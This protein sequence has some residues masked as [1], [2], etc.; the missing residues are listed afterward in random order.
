MSLN[1]HSAQGEGAGLAASLRRLGGSFVAVLHTRGELLAREFER[2]TSRLTRLVLLGLGALFFLS[3]G[4]LTLTLFVIVFFWDSH[5]LTVIALLTL[6]YLALGIG[7]AFLARRSAARVKRP[8]AASVAQFKKD[9]E[10]FA[11]HS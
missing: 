5:R 10:H 7:L 8:F 11:S 6:L 1:A 3:L 4:A 2:E 9:R